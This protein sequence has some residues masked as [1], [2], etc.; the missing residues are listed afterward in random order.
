MHVRMTEEKGEKFYDGPSWLG[1][2]NSLINSRVRN[3]ILKKK[4]QPAALK[5]DVQ[6]SRVDTKMASYAPC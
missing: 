4:M 5:T 3:D 6:F 2:V 1:N